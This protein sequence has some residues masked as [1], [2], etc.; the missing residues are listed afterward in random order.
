M[1]PV[2]PLTVRAVFSPHISLKARCTLCLVFPPVRRSIPG[3]SALSVLV[4]LYQRHSWPLRRESS[5]FST[6]QHLFYTLGD[7]FLVV[8]LS[9]LPAPTF[10]FGRSGSDFD[11][12]YLLLV[13]FTSS[14]HLFHAP[15]LSRSGLLDCLQR[16]ATSRVSSPIPPINNTPS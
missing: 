1:S 5:V 7:F 4:F 8:P 13:F 16:S 10:P 14:G 9:S 11:V 6:P 3:L 15:P 2:F 12:V